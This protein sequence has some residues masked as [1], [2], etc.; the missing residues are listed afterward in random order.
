MGNKE[1][2]VANLVNPKEGGGTGFAGHHDSRR[3]IVDFTKQ[4]NTYMRGRIDK[5]GMNA[6]ATGT[7]YT[8]HY[9]P[10]SAYY[11]YNGP[12]GYILENDGYF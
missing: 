5:A 10:R 9:I 1:Y 8:G 7:L 12:E 4:A 11:Y 3:D 2:Q 6:T